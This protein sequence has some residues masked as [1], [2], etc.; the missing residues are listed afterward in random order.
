MIAKPEAMAALSGGAGVVE[1]STD[2][3]IDELRAMLVEQKRLLVRQAAMLEALDRRREEIEELVEIAMPIANQALRM[4]IDRMA[5]CETDGTIER[6]K[7]ATAAVRGAIASHPPTLWRL[8]K[9]LRTP[10][11]RRGLAALME[12]VHAVGSGG[13]EAP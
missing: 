10:E 3:S 8:W 4:G 13:R 2:E 6:A 5:R 12:I 7:E 11:S 1:H 9:R